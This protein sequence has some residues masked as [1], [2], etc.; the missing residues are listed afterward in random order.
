MINQETNIRRLVRES[1]L[2]VTEARETSIYTIG[3]DT[4]NQR[5]YKMSRFLVGFSPVGTPKSL[6]RVRYIKPYCGTAGT[7]GEREGENH[8][9]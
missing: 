2:T 5:T 7:S 8:D 3:R 4:E 9:R 6:G 1:E